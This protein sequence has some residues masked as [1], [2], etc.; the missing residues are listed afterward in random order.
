MLEIQTHNP[1]KA[2]PRLVDK[3]RAIHDMLSLRWPEYATGDEV[4]DAAVR[5]RLEMEDVQGEYHTPH[6]VVRTIEDEWSRN[7]YEL[8]TED[9][10]RDSAQC[11]QLTELLCRGPFAAANPRVADAV[12]LS[13][14]D[15]ITELKSAFEKQNNGSSYQ[16]TSTFD[17][18]AGLSL[19]AMNYVLAGVAVQLG[20][21][22]HE[23]AM[24]E[25]NLQAWP[26]LKSHDRMRDGAYENAYLVASHDVLEIPEDDLRE[27]ESPATLT[28]RAVPGK[29]FDAS[30]RFNS[31]G[32]AEKFYSRTVQNGREVPLPD[33][34]I[35]VDYDD[36]SPTGFSLDVGRDYRNNEHFVRSAD[37]AGRSLQ[38]ERAEGSHFTGRFA[39]VSKED[40]EEFITG[41]GDFLDAD[42][43][44]AMLDGYY[45]NRQG[46]NAPAEVPPF[47]IPAEPRTGGSRFYW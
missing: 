3:T 47:I 12:R 42:A 46:L 45:K 33:F 28:L 30:L 13:L 36:K 15:A 27:L 20:A 32:L 8:R 24:A 35:R 31:S 18:D 44:M 22:N 7:P 14:H 39:G 9:V 1:E 38:A 19:Q 25:Y 26:G 43:R 6:T 34:S 17:L 2:S 11:R 21:V 29:R 10:E 41:I 16:E 23:D 40:M 37:P 4:A 5:H